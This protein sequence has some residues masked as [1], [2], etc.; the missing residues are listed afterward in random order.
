[1][2]SVLSELTQHGARVGYFNL[3]IGCYI[4]MGILI[5]LASGPLFTI[6]KFWL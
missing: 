2:V 3:V 1:M 6:E 5:E 4:D